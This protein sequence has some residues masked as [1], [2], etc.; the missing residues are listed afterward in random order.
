LSSSKFG[1]SFHGNFFYPLLFLLLNCDAV[2]IGVEQQQ[3]WWSID[4]DWMIRHRQCRWFANAADKKMSTVAAAAVGDLFPAKNIHLWLFCLLKSW[5][6]PTISCLPVKVPKVASEEEVGGVPA[7]E[8][9]PPPPPIFPFGVL[10][11]V[12]VA[13]VV[14]VVAEE[15]ALLLRDNMPSPAS[16]PLALLCRLLGPRP[17]P[18]PAIDVEPTAEADVAAVVAANC[19]AGY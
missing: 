9:A 16:L 11:G 7:K 17:P 1:Q 13:V 18:P 15:I 2:A 3:R 5:K 10:F 4:G 6:S 12:F 19:P 14:V 8:S